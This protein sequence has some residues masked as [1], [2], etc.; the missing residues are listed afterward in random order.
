[1]EH[2]IFNSVEEQIDQTRF[3]LLDFKQAY[4]EIIDN[5]FIGFIATV[6]SITH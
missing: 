3:D 5:F 2:P 6:R 1:M 4:T